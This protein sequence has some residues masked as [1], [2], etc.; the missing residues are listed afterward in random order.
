M[1]YEKSDFYHRRKGI[2]KKLFVAFVLCVSAI[3]LASG[4]FAEEIT[5]A[6]FY[7]PMSAEENHG[8]VEDVFKGFMEANHDIAVSEEVYQ[9]DQIDTKSIMDFKAQIGH[10]VMMWCPAAKRTM[11]YCGPGAGSR[12]SI[13]SR[14][15][16]WIW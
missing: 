10:D 11:K 14:R 5:F 16:M 4:A 12:S 3:T 13:S 9:W 1:L 6:H 15:I 2:M 7:D 8:W